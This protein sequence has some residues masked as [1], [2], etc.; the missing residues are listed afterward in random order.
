LIVCT[1]R[2]IGWTLVTLIIFKVLIPN[3]VAV[4]VL[5][6]PIIFTLSALTVIIPTHITSIAAITFV[7][8]VVTIPL[9]LIIWACALI[10]IIKF[11][12]LYAGCTMGL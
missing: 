9:V 10:D 2:A 3:A 1:L 6:G 8:V 7:A 12:I 11:K 5:H 4:P